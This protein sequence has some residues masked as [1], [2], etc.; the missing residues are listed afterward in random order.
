MFNLFNKT[1]ANRIL[2]GKKIFEDCLGE[3]FG[4]KWKDSTIK[5]T[6]KKVPFIISSCC[7]DYFFAYFRYNQTLCEF[8]FNGPSYL[9]LDYLHFL[10]T[11]EH[12]DFELIKSRPEEFVD[13]GCYI[14]DHYYLLCIL[15][16][17]EVEYSDE[18]QKKDAGP[19]GG[20]LELL[21]NIKENVRAALCL[22]KD[23]DVL[24]HISCMFMHGGGPWE[25]KKEFLLTLIEGGNLP[26]GIL[27]KQTLRCLDRDIEVNPFLTCRCSKYF[28]DAIKFNHKINI[29]SFYVLE[30]Q[31]YIFGSGGLNSPLHAEFNKKAII[32]NIFNFID[33][34]VLIQDYVFLLEIVT[35]YFSENTSHCAR[36][37]INQI[38]KDMKPHEQSLDVN[39]TNP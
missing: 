18:E 23:G 10:L 24:T 35:I 3:E 7:S 34:A 15:R 16:R 6:D 29:H 28:F 25:T 8:D 2:L 19:T 21:E 5:C 4:E 30:Y 39:N 11:T 31:K 17:L 27:K 20:S 32:E 1:H 14:V 9:I 33:F 22:P 37:E 12:L 13:F 38:I 26:G 36:Q